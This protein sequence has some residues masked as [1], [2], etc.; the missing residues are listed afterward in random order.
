[1]RPEFQHEVPVRLGPKDTTWPI[2]SFP[3]HDIG[4]ERNELMCENEPG[5]APSYDS[6]QRFLRPFTWKG[7]E[8][9]PR[10]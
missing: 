7:I 3:N 8:S 1:M 4:S 9:D 10:P 6:Y 2:S 5:N